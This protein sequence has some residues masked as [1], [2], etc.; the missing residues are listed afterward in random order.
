M[1]KIFQKKNLESHPDVFSDIVNGC[2]FRGNKRVAPDELIE[3]AVHSQYKTDDSKLHEQE[4]DIAKYWKKDDV[5]FILYGIEN[6]SAV[7]R[8]MPFRV[9]GY[10]GAAY[11]QQLLEDKS[12]KKDTGIA[13]TEKNTIEKKAKTKKRKKK[14]IA[15]VVIIV[16]YFGTDKKWN[17]PCSIKEL[18]HIPE[19]LEDYVNDYK[20]HVVN[21]AWLTDKEI[22]YFESDFKIVAKFFVRKR[23]GLGLDAEDTQVIK[24]VDEVMKLLSV[25]TKDD[26]YQNLDF[27]REK[28]GDVRMCEVAQKLIDEG[29]QQG[30]Q[31]GIREG[32]QQGI[33]EGIREGKQLGIQ[34]TLIQLVKDGLLSVSEAAKRMN[35][36]ENNFKALL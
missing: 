25:M 17:Q 23:R 10:D 14:V 8:Y 11:R 1:K 30:I 5:N 9:I 34:E 27:S 13:K 35:V 33:R 24:H 20:I 26:A 16:L 12:K 15:P 36:S 2:V 19:G 29:K 6:Q 28:K 21:I 3:M 4:R 32:K 7:D 18:L 22:E 31:E